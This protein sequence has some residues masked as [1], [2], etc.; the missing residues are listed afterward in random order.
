MLVKVKRKARD[1]SGALRRARNQSD[2][3][4]SQRN[5]ASRLVVPAHA[6][7]DIHLLSRAP[8]SRHRRL[9]LCSLPVP[10]QFVESLESWN[11]FAQSAIGRTW[12]PAHRWSWCFCLFLI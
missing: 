4:S 2:Q 6:E 3:D 10:K 9:S 8:R 1:I 11:S 12:Q 5:C 7:P